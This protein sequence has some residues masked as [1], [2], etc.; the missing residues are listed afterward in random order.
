MDGGGYT[1]SSICVP[2]GYDRHGSAC[3]ESALG[4][5]A[6]HSV[7]FRIQRLGGQVL[8]D[9]YDL[10]IPNCTAAAAPDLTRT[11][12]P[13]RRTTPGLAGNIDAGLQGG[14]NPGKSRSDGRVPRHAG[15]SDFRKMFQ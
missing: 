7:V 14:E 1:R 10:L 11:C 5:H 12:N 4:V 9:R 3:T 13:G 8:Q 6:L 15:R 2:P